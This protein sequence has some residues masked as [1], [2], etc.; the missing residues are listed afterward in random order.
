[1]FKPTSRDAVFANEPNPV[2]SSKGELYILTMY[3]MASGKQ[4]QLTLLVNFPNQM[5]TMRSAL[6]LTSSP[7][8]STQSQSWPRSLPREWPNSTETRSSGYTDSPRRLYITKALSSTL[9]SWRSCTN[10]FTSKEICQLHTTL[11]Q[12][13]KQN[14]WIKNSNCIWGCTSTIGNWTRQTG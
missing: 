9:P 1:M 3:Q 6:L 14:K 5:G 12:T 13:D 8:R 11:R 10:S 2:V 4:S 7:S